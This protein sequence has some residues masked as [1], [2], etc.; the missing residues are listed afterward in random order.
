MSEISVTLKAHGGHDS[1]WIVVKGANTAEVSAHLKD[2]REAGAFS[3]V[4][5]IAD[6]FVNAAVEGQAVGVIQQAFP[7][8][9]VMP[10]AAQPPAQQAQQ[11]QQ[12]PP[13]QMQQGGFAG[14]PVPPG[15]PAYQPT[16]SSQQQQQYAPPPPQGQYAPPPQQ[17]QYQPTPQPQQGATPPCE[18]CGAPTKHKTGTSSRGPWAA[19]F[20][21]S[22]NR[23][24]AKFLN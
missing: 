1:P 4:K 16:P 11:W 17:P 21:S 15:P 18:T 13:S 5:V 8:A 7:G 6:E 12:A 19:L 22:G 10:Q 2:L 9:S 14:P 3:A 23:D 20:C 24:H